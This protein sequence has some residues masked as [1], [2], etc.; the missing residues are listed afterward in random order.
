VCEV[1]RRY[2]R[3]LDTRQAVLQHLLK[4]KLNDVLNRGRRETNTATR[5]DRRIWR[6]R[7]RESKVLEIAERDRGRGSVGLQ[8]GCG[9]A[10][11]LA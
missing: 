1:L 7:I 9:A 2:V 10:L 6:T 4:E 11:H 5:S 3:L 8:P